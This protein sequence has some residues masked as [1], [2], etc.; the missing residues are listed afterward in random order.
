MGIDDLVSAEHATAVTPANGTK[1]NFRALYIGGGGNVTVMMRG[2][3]TVEFVG[4]AAGTILPIRVQE[5]RA[6]TT[7]TSILGLL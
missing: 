6:A 3:A 5:V 2:G 1:V 4:V 7:A